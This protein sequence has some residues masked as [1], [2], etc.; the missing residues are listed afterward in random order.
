[1]FIPSFPPRELAAH[2]DDPHWMVFDCRH[3]LVD[4]AAGSRAYAQSHI[5]GAHFINLD[6]DLSGAKNGR[7]GRHPL[8]DAARSARGSP[9]SACAR[10]CRSSPT[11]PSGGPYAARLWWMLRWVGHDSVAVLDGG[12]NAWLKAGQAVTRGSARS[13]ARRLSPARRAPSPSTPPSSN[14]KSAARARASSMRA[15]PTVSAA[16]TKRSIRSAATSPARAIASSRTTS[17]TD[18]CFKPADVLQA[19]IF[20]A[21]RRGGAR[22]GRASMRLRRHRL[23]QSSGDGN[24]RA[25]RL[26]RLSGI[27]ERVVQRPAP[28]G[29]ASAT[30][31][32]R[33]PAKRCLLRRG[34]DDRGRYLRLPHVRIAAGK[35]LLALRE[36]FAAMRVGAVGD[37]SAAPACALERRIRVATVRS[38]DPEHRNQ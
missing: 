7:N 29:R 28:A 27:V 11:T 30:N 17:A 32:R 31:P 34:G 38:R 21:A 6:R 20:R 23:P 37:Q 36:D 3:D 35:A 9:R 25:R 10:A 19:G 1:M 16:K 8:P 24:R 26:A 14:R 12:W 5:A 2:L 33:G 13:R 4:T 15:A 22:A 18:G